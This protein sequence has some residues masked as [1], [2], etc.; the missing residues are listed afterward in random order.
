VKK[1]KIDYQNEKIGNFMG[2]VVGVGPWIR[3]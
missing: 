3:I 1:K 2:R